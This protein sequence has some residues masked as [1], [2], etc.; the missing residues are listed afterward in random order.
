MRRLRSTSGLFVLLICVSI[1]QGTQDY[2]ARLISVVD[3]LKTHLVQSRPEW[4]HSSVEPIKG[5]RNVSVNNWELNGHLVRVSILAYA[6]E[7][8]AAEAMRAFASKSRTLDRLPELGDGGYSWGMGG[9]NICF[10]K[11]DLTIWVST[12]V[13][14][15]R[16]AVKLSQEFAKEVEV[17][18]TAT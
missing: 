11:G 5:S 7:G 3:K 17:A 1:A 2:S 12:T 10:R 8:E 16:E 14:N 9:S 6:S 13:T 15:L 18:L 4:R